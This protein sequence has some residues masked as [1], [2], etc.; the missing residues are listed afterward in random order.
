LGRHIIEESAL[1]FPIDEIRRRNAA[2]LASTICLAHQNELVSVRK[3]QAQ[4]KNRVN[5]TEHSGVRPDAE[6]EREHSHGGE[7]GVLQQLAEG[8]FEIIHNGEPPSG[9]PLLRGG[10]GYSMP[11]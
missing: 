1:L 4:K 9:P 3:R 6:R 8:E 11:A 5:D 10:P 7:A 2:R